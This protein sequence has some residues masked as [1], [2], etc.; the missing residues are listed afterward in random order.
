MKLTLSILL[1]LFMSVGCKKKP[2]GVYVC[3]DRK[4]N[5]YHENKSCRN[6]TIC[7]ED[8]LHVPY[9]DRNKDRPDR[10]IGYDDG[11]DNGPLGRKPCGLCYGK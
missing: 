1:I 8:I 3:T 6:L 2:D 11:Y 7:T 4:H 10:G 5:T 9:S